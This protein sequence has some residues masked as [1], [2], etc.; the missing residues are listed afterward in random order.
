[1]PE[2]PL[3]AMVAELTR[4]LAATPFVP[5]TIVTVNNQRF[6]VHT[7]DHLTITGIHRTVI[8]EA[9]EWKAAHINPV[10]I[11]TLEWLKPAA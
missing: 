7:P 10:H 11:A 5:F 8:W 3:T 1:M 4:R 2:N 6:E 9:D